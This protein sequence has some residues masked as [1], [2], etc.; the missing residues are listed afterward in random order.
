MNMQLILIKKVVISEGVTQIS[1][2]A[3]YGCTS[4]KNIPSWYKE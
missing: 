2:A 3:F 4:L 1:T